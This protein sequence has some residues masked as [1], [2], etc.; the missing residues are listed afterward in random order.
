MILVNKNNATTLTNNIFQWY[1]LDIFIVVVI[2]D[3]LLEL[4]NFYY[5]NNSLLQIN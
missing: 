3:I 4:Y 1:V 2:N 5:T